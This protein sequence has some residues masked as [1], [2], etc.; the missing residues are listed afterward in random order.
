M[1][2]AAFASGAEYLDVVIVEKLDGSDDLTLKVVRRL[3]LQSSSR[4]E[5]IKALGEQLQNILRE[6]HVEK[7]FVKKSSKGQNI[8]LSH[9]EAAELRGVGIFVATSIAN[10]VA[11]NPSNLA[12]TFGERKPKEYL[13]ADDY[14]ASVG[15]ESMEKRYREPCLLILFGMR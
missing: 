2:V 9:L 8:S 3:Q 15:L 4:P 7:L 1:I 13:K 10:V 6:A 12:K 11:I 14:W 5:A